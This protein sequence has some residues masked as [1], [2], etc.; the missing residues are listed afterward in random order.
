MA[1]RGHDA[2]RPQA[3]PGDVAD[4]E[5]R[6]RAEIHDLVPVAADLGPGDTR[7]VAH[8]DL[9]TW[10]R[11]ELPREEALLQR[12]RSGPL[13]A[14]ELRDG[15]GQTLGVG[16]PA[17]EGLGQPGRRPRSSSR[18]RRRRSTGARPA[19]I[20]RGRRPAR[21]RRSAGCR[22]R[23][24]PPRR[25]APRGAARR[26]S[27]A[28]SVRGPSGGVEVQG[29]VDVGERRIGLRGLGAVRRQALLGV[30]DELGRAVRAPRTRTRAEA[31]S[32]S[33]RSRTLIIPAAD[34]DRSRKASISCSS[35]S[36][37]AGAPMV[38]TGS[39]SSTANSAPA[40]NGWPLVGLALHRPG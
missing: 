3:A 12:H 10:D 28:A 31:S 14:V 35:R 13:L 40:T 39:G 32:S 36:S 18:R 16:A 26:C 37:S 15:V 34:S 20:H 5:Q 22:R 2:G 25:A 17:L 8:G 23:R 7:R 38:S 4:H 29:V 11:R 24:W 21:S 33:S 9:D 30:D 1:H 6:P 19:A 27:P